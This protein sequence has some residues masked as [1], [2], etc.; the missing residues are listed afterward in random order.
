MNHSQ[1]LALSFKGWAG[2]L[3]KLPQGDFIIKNSKERMEME[4]W[5]VVT[6]NWV[7]LLLPLIM[8]VSGLFTRFGLPKRVNWFAGYRTP[9]ACKNQDTWG[10]A[11]RYWGRM[12][13]V[14]GFILIALSIVGIL[15]IAR[16]TLTLEPAR[17]TGVFAIGTLIIFLVSMIPTE[18]ALRK[19]FDKNGQRR[20]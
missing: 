15:L 13:I 4:V 14:F 18:L 5:E 8:L 17:F 2:T 12:M 20:R 11:H 7:A 3:I 19:N 1:L 9:L 6:A 16:G 10:F